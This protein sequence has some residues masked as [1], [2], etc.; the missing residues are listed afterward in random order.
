[1]DI[2]ATLPTNNPEAIREEARLLVEN[3]STPQGGFIV[4]NYGDAEAL[5][6]RPE[7]T[8]VM[9]EAFVELQDF[10]Q[11]SGCSAG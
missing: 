2:Q 7:M 5:G 6:A 4:F 1:V 10:W 8:R 11:Q 9:F 3:W